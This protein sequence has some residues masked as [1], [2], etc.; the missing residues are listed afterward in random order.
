MKSFHA[1]GNAELLRLVSATQP[2]SGQNGLLFYR[3]VVLSL[4][5]CPWA[6]R[7]NHHTGKSAAEQIMKI[8]RRLMRKRESVND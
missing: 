1:S 3:G 6:M 8:V 7:R 2:R 5:D 4:Q